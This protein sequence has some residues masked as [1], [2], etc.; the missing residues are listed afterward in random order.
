MVPFPE[1][2]KREDFGS[3]HALRF[4]FSTDSGKPDGKH[5]TIICKHY[6]NVL[7]D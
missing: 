1:N 2:F 6:V 3:D 7:F 4:E 5:R